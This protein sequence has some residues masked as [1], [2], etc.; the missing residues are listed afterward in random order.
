M[1]EPTTKLQ[2][3]CLNR[4]KNW[5][6]HRRDVNCKGDRLEYNGMVIEQAVGTNQYDD[7]I[8]VYKVS[9]DGVLVSNNA[10]IDSACRDMFRRYL[11][12]DIVMR[13]NIRGVVIGTVIYVGFVGAFGALFVWLFQ[14]CGGSVPS[15]MYEDNISANNGKPGVTIT[16][17]ELDRYNRA[18][19]INYYAATKKTR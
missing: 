15:Y 2:Q 8:T 19:T 3:E 1:N 13:D 16:R 6:R 4:L 12:M 14:K 7:F 18:H 17:D 10:D 9:M 11:K 5:P